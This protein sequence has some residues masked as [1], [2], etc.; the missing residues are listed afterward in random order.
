MHIIVE[1]PII[2]LVLRA[3][4]RH[5]HLRAWL[6]IEPSRLLSIGWQHGKL[7]TPVAKTMASCWMGTAPPSLLHRRCSVH[8]ACIQRNVDD[9]SLNDIHTL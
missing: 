2:H 9:N 3:F 5:F 7:R 4:R 6:V 8:Q 1:V